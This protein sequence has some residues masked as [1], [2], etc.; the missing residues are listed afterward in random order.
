MAPIRISCQHSSFTDAPCP[1]TLRQQVLVWA[2]GVEES[3]QPWTLQ[4]E[5][6]HRL[7][8]PSTIHDPLL[9]FKPGPGVGLDGCFA[10]DLAHLFV[11]KLRIGNRQRQTVLLLPQRRLADEHVVVAGLVSLATRRGE[12]DA[13]AEH[14]AQRVEDAAEAAGRN[15]LDPGVLAAKEER[16]L[17]PPVVE[18]HLSQIVT[19][20]EP[21][22]GCPDVPSLPRKVSS[23]QEPPHLLQSPIAG[24][25]LD[26]LDAVARGLRHAFRAGVEVPPVKPPRR[27]RQS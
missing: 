5:Q 9:V 6:V 23:P 7:A 11:V 19:L 26:A 1:L 18:P 22:T 13:L 27:P 12:V 24:P 10:L 8:L 21:H 4:L 16:L 20:Q 2:V 3:V 15:G 14:T 25:E 17:G